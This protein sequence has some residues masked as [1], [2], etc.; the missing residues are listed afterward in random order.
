MIFIKKKFA[1]P[2]TKGY[3]MQEVIINGRPA[4]SNYNQE[5]PNVEGYNKRHYDDGDILLVSPSTKDTK[6]KY[7]SYLYNTVITHKANSNTF[8]IK[9][10]TISTDLFG[11]SRRVKEDP[12][13]IMLRTDNGST[14][15]FYQNYDF[16]T[17][18]LE[19]PCESDSKFTHIYNLVPGEKYQ[20][21]VFNAS[22]TLISNIYKT[23]SQYGE[24]IVLGQ[25]RQLYLPSMRNT[26]DSGGY[27]TVDGTKRV[28]YGKIYRGSQF[29]PGFYNWDTEGAYN[30]TQHRRWLD[31]DPSS[32]TK[33]P[34]GID[35]HDIE[36][37]KRLGVTL[38]VDLRDAAGSEEYSS[39]QGVW[40]ITRYRPFFIPELD[41]I[42]YY[43]VSQNTNNSGITSYYGL[44]KTSG[45][46]PTQFKKFIDRILTEFANGGSIYVHCQ[47]GRDRT[48]SFMAFLFGLLGVNDDGILADY[49]L[50]SYCSY[51]GDR[52][53]L[54]Y[55]PDTPGDYPTIPSSAT[56]FR[57]YV[58]NWAKTY[59]GVTDEQIAQLKEYLL[60]DLPTE[61][62]EA[63]LRYET[64][65][66]E[67]PVVLNY[68]NTTHHSA[69]QLAKKAS[70]ANEYSIYAPD[71]QEY[72]EGGV[73]YNAGPSYTWLKNQQLAKGY[74]Y[75]SYR[76]PHFIAADYHVGA[77]PN[78][79]ELENPNINSV[80]ITDT[81]TNKTYTIANRSVSTSG[82]TAYFGGGD[83]SSLGGNANSIYS[84]SYQAFPVIGSST[85]VNVLDRLK[86]FFTKGS[87]PS[88]SYAVKYAI[89]LSTSY[90][91]ASPAY[92]T[93]ESSRVSVNGSKVPVFTYDGSNTDW[94]VW[95]VL[96]TGATLTSPKEYKAALYSSDKTFIKFYTFYAP[97]LH[98]NGPTKIWNLIPGRM[99]HYQAKDVNNTVLEEGNV[100]PVGQLRSIFLEGMRNVRD[101]GGWICYNDQGNA[102]GSIKYDKLYRG[103]RPETTSTD[104]RRPGG[105]TIND[106]YMMKEFINLG[107]E[108]D[109]RES[110][111]GDNGNYY[112]GSSST[113][114]PFSVDTSTGKIPRV[115]QSCASYWRAFDCIKWN[116]GDEPNAIKSEFICLGYIIDNLKR[117]ESVYFH[118]AQG[119][120][121]TA[122]VAMI[123]ESLIGVD[124]DQLLK[125]WELT[126]FSG[127]CN[128]D[129]VHGT[130]SNESDY[131]AMNNDCDDP[132]RSAGSGTH[133][134]VHLVEV[135][136]N[137]QQVYGQSTIHANIIKWFETVCN[138]TVLTSSPSG[139]FVFLNKI[140]YTEQYKK[141]N[142]STAVYINST[143]TK[144]TPSS[145]SASYLGLINSKSGADFTSSA[146]VIDFLKWKLVDYKSGIRTMAVLGDS[147]SA[148]KNDD[149]CPLQDLWWYKYAQSIGLNPETDVNNNSIGNTMVSRNYNNEDNMGCS[150]SRINN[151][152]VNGQDPDI[153]FV[154]MGGNDWVNSSISLGT[155]TSG[156]TLPGD[157]STPE[158]LDFKPAFALM[159]SRIK[160]TYQHSL[161][162]CINEPRVTNATVT[163]H[164]WDEWMYAQI[165][166]AKE[167]DCPVVD[168][169]H[170]CGNTIKS[171][172]QS[173]NTSIYKSDQY[174]HLNALGHELIANVIK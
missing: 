169:C 102:V 50:T 162:V 55:G 80:D 28:K 29:Q 8:T 166:V 96:S 168:L 42:S 12:K 157:S 51:D 79:F 14:I 159:L 72:T 132:N 48:G 15:K 13:P 165:E 33:A 170:V 122:M 16:N 66:I 82:V 34:G 44:R 131:R 69:N 118:C 127:G 152:Q 70:T 141:D 10:Y 146:Q 161:V 26:R 18:V 155:Y 164:D 138:Y 37:I 139:T 151:L 24:F 137:L 163:G 61:Q 167:F 99:Y 172:L 174:V 73:T 154:M 39:S 64:Y 94:S 46:G 52:W 36:E 120:D 148:Y 25:I 81:V 171:T 92:A 43:S 136:E 31:T 40:K 87:V 97:L 160:N 20:Y 4:F 125:D 108:L 129:D 91:T 86:P 134:L 17:P 19:M 5:N 156:D 85:F 121:R 68:L 115:R 114:S 65:Q 135:K 105:V 45:N 56:D 173:D 57:T 111:S 89:P 93:A 133:E 1:Y 106:R 113:N 116:E 109:L 158:N 130:V 62:E 11:D 9:T 90:S 140:G 124:D 123:I 143:G 35:A 83:D 117:N 49:E 22:N 27:L 153:I 59:A 23:S 144:A 75:D 71:I 110:N 47:Q 67:N 21:K 112:M 3:P 53:S 142:N 78:Y 6:Y 104:V 7:D 76:D 119:A 103:S 41:G 98:T 58:I 74:K 63:P 145:V 95:N 128:N 100:M 84:V 54:Q 2:V 107:R 38:D 101:L 88:S 126:S 30:V 149:R 150:W 32:D 77:N 60:E 147:Q